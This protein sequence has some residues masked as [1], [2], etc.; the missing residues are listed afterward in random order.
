M[1]NENFHD[2]AWMQ[3][4]ENNRHRFE[5]VVVITNVVEDSCL[6]SEITIFLCLMN[7]FAKSIL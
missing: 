6:A 2:I 5:I 1:K 7:L 4:K 3:K